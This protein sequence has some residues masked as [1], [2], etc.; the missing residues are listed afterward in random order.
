MND[1]ILIGAGGHARSCIDV[2]ELSGK[3]KIAGLVDKD[4]NNKKENLNYPILGTDDDLEILRKKFSTAFIT[5]GQIKSP[6]SR[7]RLFKHLKELDY[8]LPFIFSPRAY[9]SKNAK[10]GDG[11][12]VLHD[13]I[14]NY[15]AKVGQNSIINNKVLIEHDVIVGD[16]CHISTGAILNGGVV[17]GNGSFIGSGVITKQSVSIGKNCIIGAGV[18]IKNNVKSNDIILD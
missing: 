18:V 11:T 16:H 3:Y 14:L 12:I 7:I 5:V 2:I 1:I 10:I 15:N 13:T 9:L 17:V 8:H 6:T 4:Y